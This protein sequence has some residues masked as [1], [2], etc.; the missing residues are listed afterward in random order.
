M[1]MLI[2]TK[3]I[4]VFSS[5]YNFPRIPEAMQGGKKVQVKGTLM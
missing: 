4:I 3:P 1:G 5:N 2:Y